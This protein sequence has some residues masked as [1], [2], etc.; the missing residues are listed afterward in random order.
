ML[1]IAIREAEFEVSGDGCN[2]PRLEGR[3]A[4]VARRGGAGEM[5]RVLAKGLEPRPFGAGMREPVGANG[6]GVEVR[7][8]ERGLA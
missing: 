5:V 4:V 3:L 1:G 7:D 8:G 2:E 6:F